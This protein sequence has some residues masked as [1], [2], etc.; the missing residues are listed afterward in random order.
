MTEPNVSPVNAEPVV[1]VEPQNT[2]PINNEP[3]EPTGQTVNAVD[4]EVTPPTVDVKQVQSA[5]ENARYAAIRREAETKAKEKA[6]DELIAEMYGESHG[7]RTY[8]DY[9]K[10]L[11][12]AARQEEIDR[13]VQQNIPQEYAEKLTKVDQIERQLAEQQK[14]QEEQARKSREYEDFFSYFKLVNGRDFD[15]NTDNIPGEVFATAQQNG[16]PLR[17]AYAEHL[18][19]DYRSKL[20]GVEQGQRTAEANFAN[21]STS[22]G[23]VNGNGQPEGAITQADVDAH[24][25]DTAWMMKH[26]DQIEKLLSK[27]R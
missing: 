11:E 16:I 1:N 3:A 9:Q 5:E 23:S 4:G 2:E 19:N 15:P 27:G 6:R 21:A 22:P 12:E 20:T 7:I 26:Y 25:N 13:L 14:A 8:A 24:A 18:A 10:A 17:Y